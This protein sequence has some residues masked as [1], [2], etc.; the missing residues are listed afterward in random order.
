M[1][2]RMGGTGSEGCKKGLDQSI[3]QKKKFG[4]KKF[5]GYFYKIEH[6]H[7]HT[8]ASLDVD[9]NFRCVFT[10]VKMKYGIVF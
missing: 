8:K 6:T 3:H 2:I 1:S 7:T 9:S 5:D 10:S 4:H